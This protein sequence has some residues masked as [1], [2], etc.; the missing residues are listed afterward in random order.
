MRPQTHEGF[1]ERDA[2]AIDEDEAHLEPRPT[3]LTN[4]AVIVPVRELNLV[5]WQAVEYARRMSKNVVATHV[6]R[7]GQ[8]DE[9]LVERWRRLIPDV[10]LI[11]IDSPYRT[12]LGPFLA[13]ADRVAE[14]SGGSV[15]VVVPEFRPDHWWQN[16]LHNRTGRLIE[17]AA[18][19]HPRLAVTVLA[20]RLPR[21]S[22]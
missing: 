13:Y 18:E 17:E 3:D 7:E 11:T 20:V 22:A 2:L 21:A 8:P 15:T 16:V 14:T 10:P 5:T 19:T 9:V 12:F 1:T 4:H 6:Q